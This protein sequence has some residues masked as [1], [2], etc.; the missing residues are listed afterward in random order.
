MN[1]EKLVYTGLDEILFQKGNFNVNVEMKVC[2]SNKS[3]IDILLISYR[4][5][6]RDGF[7]FFSFLR[8]NVKLFY[9]AQITFPLHS[10]ILIFGLQSFEHH[11]EIHHLIP[12]GSLCQH[13]L[14]QILNKVTSIHAF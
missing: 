5:H 10:C 2:C 4:Y 1:H 3:S 9:L 11:Q 8:V 7:I 14:Q 6:F 12:K 13:L